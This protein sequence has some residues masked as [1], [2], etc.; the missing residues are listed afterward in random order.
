VSRTLVCLT[1]LLAAVAPLSAQVR[2]QG[3]PV[4]MAL[5]PAPLLEPSLK[6]RLLPDRAE[7]VPGN[8][9][10]IYYRSEAM[11]VENRYL[12]DDIQEDHWDR[13]FITPIKDLPLTEVETKVG[14]ARNFLHE[15]EVATHYRRCDWEVDSR[16][17]GVG[18]FTPDLRGFRRAAL[19]LGVRARYHMARRQFPEALQSLQ[20]GY[21]LARHLGQGPSFNHVVVAEVAANLMNYQLEDFVQQPGAPNLYWAL[22]VLPRPFFDIAPAVEEEGTV[23]ERTWPWLKRLGEGPMSPDEV[24]AAHDNIRR[25]LERYNITPPDGERA[26]QEAYPEAKRALLGQGVSAKEVDAMPPFQVVALDAVRQ[27]RRAWQE[28]TKWFQLPGGWREPG[29]RKAAERYRATVGRLDRLFFGGLI[30][31]LGIGDPDTLN[32]V[33]TSMDQIERNV[34][35]LRCLEALRLYAAGH[36]GKL[37][38]TLGD[39]TEVPVPPDP[40]TGK[41][42]TYVASGDQARLSAPAPTDEPPPALQKLVYEVTLKP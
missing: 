8:A 32:K 16:S 30:H 29:Y 23:L 13:W 18:L 9:A 21:A 15:I 38:A 41:P 28:Y 3:E 40:I 1:V 17:E 7:L 6:Y 37:P 10:T 25:T 39:V 27:Y 5:H 34:A 24:R 42:F 20:T 14:F 22:A 35:A 26:V 31:A 36:G 19:L 2:R 11:F 12:L 33:Y 4:P